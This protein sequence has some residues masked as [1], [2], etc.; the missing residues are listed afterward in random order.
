MLLFKNIL[1]LDRI[2]DIR[3]IKQ[4]LLDNVKSPNVFSL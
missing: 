3:Y 2:I 1:F 4:I